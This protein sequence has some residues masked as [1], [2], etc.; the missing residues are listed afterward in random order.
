[1]FFVFLNTF[2]GLNCIKVIN[3]SSL[4]Q[5]FSVGTKQGNDSN[6]NLYYAIRFPYFISLTDQRLLCGYCDVL[7]IW[8]LTFVMTGVQISPTLKV[9]WWWQW[10]EASTE[11]YNAP[12]TLDFFDKHYY[13]WL[14]L[15]QRSTSMYPCPSICTS[16]RPCTLGFG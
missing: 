4:Y 5:I 11:E 16:I 3:F 14:P 2:Y 9:N 10:S 1:V 8:I 7:V 12:M 15:S 6:V 13:F